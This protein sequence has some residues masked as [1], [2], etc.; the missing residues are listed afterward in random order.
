MKLLRKELKSSQGLFAVTSVSL[1]F[2]MDVV[3][4]RNLSKE[5]F[6]RFVNTFAKVGLKS[7]Q[8]EG[9]KGLHQSCRCPET[10]TKTATLT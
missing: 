7:D 3:L 6:I 4:K 8:Q 5:C 10:F 9:D 1:R 2:L